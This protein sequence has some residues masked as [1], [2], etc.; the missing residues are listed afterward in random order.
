MNFLKKNFLVMAM[1]MLVCLTD[2][3]VAMLVCYCIRMCRSIMRMSDKMCMNVFMITNQCVRNYK[4][5][6][7]YHK[8]QAK[9]VHNCK[10]L[11]IHNECQKCSYKWCNRIIRTRLC[12]TQVTLGSN[13]H[14]NAK[15]IRYKS[16]RHRQYH[17]LYFR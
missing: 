5:S 17:I 16:K 12:R 3:I 14:K 9:E 11:S 1:A 13:I 15:A 8:K 6:T 10:L 7:C 2:M 4:Y